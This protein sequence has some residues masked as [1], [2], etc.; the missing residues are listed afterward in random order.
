MQFL[1]ED[2]ERRI[3][4]AAARLAL[5]LEVAEIMQLV[6]DNRAPAAALNC[7]LFIGTTRLET[8][9]SALKRLWRKLVRNSPESWFVPDFVITLT[10]AR[11]CP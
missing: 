9:S 4:D 10:H 5:M 1:V 3:P 2:G 11:R 7:W 6:P 8:G